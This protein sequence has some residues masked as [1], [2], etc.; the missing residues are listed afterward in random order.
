V[1]STM[2]SDSTLVLTRDT[3]RLDFISNESGN[4]KYIH[5]T[6]RNTTKDYATFFY[7]YDGSHGSYSVNKTYAFDVKG[8][9]MEVHLMNVPGSD[10][11]IYT[12]I[13]DEEGN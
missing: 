2:N 11:V 3:T 6:D 4:Y 10:T 7:T 5:V 12:K 13:Y 9:I 1:D 8:S